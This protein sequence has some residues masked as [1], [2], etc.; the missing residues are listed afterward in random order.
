MTQSGAAQRRETETFAQIERVAHS[1]MLS[2]SESLCRILRFLGRLSLEHPGLAVKEYLI[3]T[4]ALGRPRDF[5][6]RLDATVRVQV[7]RL[8]SKL[9]QYY[10][11]PGA[12]DAVR[13][14][15]PKGS[16]VLAVEVG[17]L[18]AKPEVVPMPVALPA[19]HG[20]MGMQVGV[21]RP[22]LRSSLWVLIPAFS[23]AAVMLG[24]WVGFL[25]SNL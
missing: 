13:L 14:R 11:G 8:R 17:K 19:N 10:L 25:L 6:P 7:G 23:L 3:A 1:E 2:G 5:D 16:Y 9:A 15:I 24:A 20:M 22:A 21:Q 4:E 12:N 18:S